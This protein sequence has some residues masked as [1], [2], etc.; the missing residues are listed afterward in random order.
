MVHGLIVKVFVLVVIRALRPLL[1]EVRELSAQYFIVR[2]RGRE[3]A[4]A[5]S[6]YGLEIRILQFDNE[7]SDSI[8]ILSIDLWARKKVFKHLFSCEDLSGIFPSEMRHS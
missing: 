6:L 7:N 3:S 1:S 4:V 5:P 2:F 8:A